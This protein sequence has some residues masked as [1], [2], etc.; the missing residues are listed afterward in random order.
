MTTHETS[1][2]SIGLRTVTSV[3]FID[4]FYQNIQSIIIIL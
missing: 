3:I 2:V 1:I 4:S